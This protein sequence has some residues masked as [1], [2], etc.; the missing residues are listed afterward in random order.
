MRRSRYHTRFWLAVSPSKAIDKF[1][2]IALQNKF[3]L[4]YRA[5][6]DIVSYLCGY[7]GEKRWRGVASLPAGFQWLS[8]RGQVPQ[9][10]RDIET[11]E[12]DRD[13]GRSTV[14]R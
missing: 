9:Q 4:V 6:G 5:Q 8:R 3:C 1:H 14:G 11:A 10:F 2:T 13:P 7:F 12:L